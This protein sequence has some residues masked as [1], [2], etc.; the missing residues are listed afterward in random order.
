MPGRSAMAASCFHLLRWD[1]NP[2][3]PSRATA[4]FDGC[5]QPPAS[6]WLLAELAAGIE[7]AILPYQGSVLPLAPRQQRRK[8][9]QDSNLRSLDGFERS[10]AEL[11]ASCVESRGWDLNPQFTEV[12]APPL[13]VC[14]PRHHSLF[15]L[16]GAGLSSERSS[17]SSREFGPLGALATSISA[18]LIR[19]LSSETLRSI[20][21]N[22]PCP[23]DRNRTGDTAVSAQRSTI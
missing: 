9:R 13:V 1:S 14:V 16:S 6:V 22:Y 19:R 15:S 8:H 21:S 7:P 20:V 17:A 2:Q 4:A 12:A 5:V 18:S 11:L 23:P 10:A 3:S